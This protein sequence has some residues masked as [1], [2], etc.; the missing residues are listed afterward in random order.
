MRAFRGFAVAA[1]LA[2]DVS[3]V[4]AQSTR[5]FKDSWFWGVKGGGMLYQV[6]SD[7]AALAPTTGIDW[8]I[9]RTNGGL[10]VAYDYAFF[11]Q[12]VVVNDSVGP[13]AFSVDG[14][15]VDLKGMHRM[16]IAGML[17]PMP[18]YRLQPY[19]GL[20][21]SLSYVAN[22]EPRGAYASR[23]QQDLVLATIQDFRA[24]ASPLFMLGMQWRL[25]MISAFGQATAT[26]ASPNFF[27]YTG[28]RWRTAL[29]GGIRYNI[30]SSIDPMR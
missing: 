10:Y 8:L 22:A 1:L 14:R 7:A 9:T 6:Q 30:G 26:Q 20:G 12:T 15:T 21:A 11:N 4:A 3:A 24:V 2:L 25:P 28:A 16:T 27:L 23:L 17:F 5:H 19:V 13:T 18:S 29:E